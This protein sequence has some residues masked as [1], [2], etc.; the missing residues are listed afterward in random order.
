MPEQLVTAELPGYPAEIGAALWRLQDARSRTLRL[1]A[2]V[3][4]ES[5]DRETRGNT[6]GAILYHLAL[7]EADWLYTEILEAPVP[8]ELAALFPA[9]ARD[10]AGILATVAGQTLDQHLDR[11]RT[12]R[13]ALLD[14]LRG[15][16]AA[17][18]HR[19]R[20]LPAYDVTPAWVLH[21]LAQ[22]EAEHRG[23]LGS[24]LA[25]FTTSP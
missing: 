10:P 2:G 8:D 13:A 18:F 6:I 3:P 5:V 25:H 19:P 7:I 24:I 22:H 12:V 17:D 21:H 14:Q 15:L 23:E 1:L 9:D 4:A 11:L 16:T 20:R